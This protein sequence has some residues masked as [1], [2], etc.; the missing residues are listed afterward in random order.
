MID[1]LKSAGQS[2]I[3]CDQLQQ[4]LRDSENRE[5]SSSAFLKKIN[6][7]FVVSAG[8]DT[9]CL[10]ELLPNY[11][12]VKTVNLSDVHFQRGEGGIEKSSRGSA[13]YQHRNHGGAFSQ[14]RTLEPSKSVFEEDELQRIFENGSMLVYNAVTNK[15]FVAGIVN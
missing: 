14:F 3:L 1:K 4:S 6:Y 2:L 13:V 5:F 7:L 9:K 11:Q 15:V 8:V 10:K 12:Y